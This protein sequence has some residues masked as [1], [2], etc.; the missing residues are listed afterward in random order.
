MRKRVSLA[1]T[2]V[3]DEALWAAYRR[4]DKTMVTKRLLRRFLTRAPGR[5]LPE[6]KNHYRGT[7]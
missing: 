5:K 2:A 1:D 7:I 3:D 4:S 6:Q